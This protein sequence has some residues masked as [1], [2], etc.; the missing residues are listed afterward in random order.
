MKSIHILDHSISLFP[1][2]YPEGDPLHY[3]SGIPM[4]FAR[5]IHK[6][7]PGIDVEVWRPER[8]S[9]QIQVWTD[10]HGVTHRIF[11]SSA[12]RYKLELSRP[13]LEAVAK[14]PQTSETYFWMHG[15]YNLHAFLLASRLSRRAAIAQSHG[16]FPG[17]ALYAISSH[18][19]RKYLYLLLH[20]IETRTLPKYPHIYAISSEEKQYLTRF[21]PVSQHQ[22]SLSPTGIDFD[23][24]SPGNK[25]AVRMKLGIDPA[26]ELV[27]FVGRLSEVKGIE[28]LLDAFPA[29]RRERTHA[30][31][32][33]VGTGPLSPGIQAQIEQMNLV[34][35][36]QLIGYVSPDSLP[37]W[38]RVADVTVVPS[39]FEWFG[40]VSAESMA[41]GTPVVV[42]ERGGGADI[43]NEFECGR[44]V[45]LRNSQA[46]AEAVCAFL[47][48]EENRQPNISRARQTFD[49]SV[50]LSRSFALLQGMVNS[51]ST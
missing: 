39:I 1:G 51:A 10:E 2:Q 27:L 41:C 5:A 40:K 43:V 49:W 31:L 35:Q 21:L 13:L 11:P 18:T 15:I 42:T 50:K 48:G 4:L 23:H 44:L 29:I 33:I 37:D 45:P 28:Y 14:T 17:K 30:Q 34:G 47:S 19:W 38:Y 7:V 6:Y 26:T 22:I 8:S 9:R 24:F 36:I 46:I 3:N 20:P 16:G 25:Q 32:F 12:L